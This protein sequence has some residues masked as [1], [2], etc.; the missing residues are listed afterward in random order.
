MYKD[1][2]NINELCKK[3]FFSNDDVT[4]NTINYLF[5]EDFGKNNVS[6]STIIVQKVIEKFY[7]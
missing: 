7:K 1:E 5:N 2:I 4:L 6:I 3:L